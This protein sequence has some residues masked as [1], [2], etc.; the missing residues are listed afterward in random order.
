MSAKLIDVTWNTYGN[1]NGLVGGRG[2]WQVGWKAGGDGKWG[3]RQGMVAGGVE[4]RGWCQVGWEAGGGG[5]WGG[6]QGVV[7]GVCGR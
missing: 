7:A 4:G 2:W 6:R 3:G 5:R 1:P